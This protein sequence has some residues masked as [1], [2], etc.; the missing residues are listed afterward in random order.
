MA[1]A[2]PPPSLR[3][4]GPSI[5]FYS[6]P[7][8][9]DQISLQGPELVVLCSWMGASL[10]YVSKYVVGYQEL[11]PASDILVIQSSMPDFIWRSQRKQKRLLQPAVDVIQNTLVKSNW[12]PEKKDAP[13]IL[14]CAMSDGGLNSATNLAHAI[15]ESCHYDTIP[16]GALILDSCPNLPHFT[17]GF[18]AFTMSLP[19]S[20]I[21]RIIGTIGILLFLCYW[22]F[23]K[24]TGD[25]SPMQINR[26]LL[27]SG[28]TFSKSHPRLY[29]VS[30]G[31]QLTNWDVV[32][33]HADEAEAAGYPTKRVVFGSSPH[34]ALITEDSA[35][36]W[37]SVRD[38]W[39]QR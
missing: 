8:K 35:K 34:C 1:H 10:K 28:A 39:D 15:K 22:W 26:R 23:L 7:T 25:R 37:G 17:R 5:S 16:N 20:A 32:L 12:M 21:P 4:L 36:Y 18:R 24:Y 19:K 2:S 30:K 14:L 29:M 11:Y 27:N 9:Q 33:Q 13:P 38:V 31:D 3:T 6:P